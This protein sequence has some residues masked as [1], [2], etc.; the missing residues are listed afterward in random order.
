MAVILPDRPNH[1][2]FRD[3]RCI[4]MSVCFPYFH[5]FSA[6]EKEWVRG[7]KEGEGNAESSRVV[8]VL[9]DDMRGNE[10]L[11]F[12]HQKCDILHRL[13][14]QRFLP[15]IGEMRPPIISFHPL[16]TSFWDW[17]CWLNACIS[18][19][20]LMVKF[21]RSLNSDFSWRCHVELS[22]ASVRK[23]ASLLL[24]VKSNRFILEQVNGLLEV[25]SIQYGCAL[26]VSVY[27]P[28]KI[29]V[30]WIK[31]TGIN[32]LVACV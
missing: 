6:R 13:D 17:L 18:F 11:D 23:E 19:V 5:H 32:V 16:H 4:I 8:S 25:C 12:V 1:G 15:C 30:I 24:G 27:C 28:F 2:T 29:K 7:W 26:Y 21:V 3:L 20:S 31:C 22:V 9:S 14:C 10:L